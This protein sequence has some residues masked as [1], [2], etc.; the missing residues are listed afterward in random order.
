MRL[1]KHLAHAGVASRRAS[2]A[3][4]AQGRVTIAGEVVRDPARDVQEGD[5]IAVDGRPVMGFEAPAVYAVNK[6]VGVLSTASD[7][8]GRPTVV[9]LLPHERRRLYPVGR[10][11]LDSEGLILLTNEGQLAHALT[12]PRFE[13]PKTYVVSVSGGRVSEAAL[14]RL[15]EGVRLDDG[16]TAPAEVKRVRDRSAAAARGGAPRGGAAK[17]AKAGRRRESVEELQVTIREGRNRQVR[18]MLEAVGHPVKRLTR[19]R[20]GALELGGLRPG[21]H[22]LLSEAEVGALR[23]AADGSGA[24]RAAP[25]EAH[26]ASRGCQVRPPA[27]KESRR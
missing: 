15:R 3:L 13:V 26:P 7:P 12:H 24:G 17:G 25:S 23:S 9:E 22:R 1:A 6:P 8:H 2:E 11:D 18:R 16:T 10:L 5:P 27:L 21:Q 14:R 19:V 4:I 20:F